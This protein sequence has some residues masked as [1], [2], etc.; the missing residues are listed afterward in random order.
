MTLIFNKK[1]CDCC[2]TK[3][4]SPI[5]EK[6]GKCCDFDEVVKNLKPRPASVD[7]IFNGKKLFLVEIKNQPLSNIDVGEVCKK[8]KETIIFLDK[9]ENELLE[10]K[11]HFYLAIPKEKLSTLYAPHKTF[12]RSSQKIAHHLERSLL[13][14][15][16]TKSYRVDL[17][18]GCVKTFPSN[19][20]LC[21]DAKKEL[22]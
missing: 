1:F 17:G 11:M 8:I 22:S 6:Y 21:E 18:Q 14:I 5:A 7:I 19:V 2:E 20:K 16:E 15:F 13:N 12:C 10:L 9:N 3:C 4:S